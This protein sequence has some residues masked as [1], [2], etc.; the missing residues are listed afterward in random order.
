[1]CIRDSGMG[2]APDMQPKTWVMALAALAIAAGA[3]PLLARFGFKQWSLVLPA[4]GFL[5]ALALLLLGKAG[6]AQKLL[7]LAAVVIYP[8][9]GVVYFAKEKP[10]NLLHAI[11]SLLAMTGVSL[12]GALFVV[13]MLS[14]RNYMTGTLVFSGVKI[15]LLYTSR[16]V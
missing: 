7:G 6:L 3:V 13:G 16:C 4:V 15:C 8:T 5:A 11:L 10:Q 14:S 2:V 1:M 12:I 9:L